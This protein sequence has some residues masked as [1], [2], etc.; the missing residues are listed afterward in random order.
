ME[1]QR[2]DYESFRAR[3]R[4]ACEK[5][6]IDPLAGST[7]FQAALVQAE[8]NI[9]T[10]HDRMAKQVWANADLPSGWHRYGDNGERVAMQAQRDWWV[11]PDYWHGRAAAEINLAVP[12]FLA[13]L[14]AMISPPD[15]TA[16]LW[17]R[18][19]AKRVLGVSEPEI[20]QGSPIWRELKAQIPPP[21]RQKRRA[22]AEL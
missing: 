8:Q 1:K 18:R 21:K 2:F 15:A 7:G 16:I 11:Y 3:F 10:H 12:A 20:E 19:D 6:G 13:D 17:T 9:I 22:L 4:V 5:R 14:Y